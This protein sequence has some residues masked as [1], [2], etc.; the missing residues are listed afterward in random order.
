MTDGSAGL[1]QKGRKF[2]V[3]VARDFAGV[4]HKMSGK[5]LQRCTDEHA[6][7]R[8]NGALPTVDQI[9]D[10]IRGSC[11]KRDQILLMNGPCIL[12]IFI[13]EKQRKKLYL[14]LHQNGSKI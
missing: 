12:N 14:T 13:I 1:Y 9:K 2:P 8:N 7:R 6:G 5:R 4:Y 10:V 11:G 3:R